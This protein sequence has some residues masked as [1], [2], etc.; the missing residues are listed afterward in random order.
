MRLGHAQRVYA[1]GLAPSEAL[2]VT[3]LKKSWWHIFFLWSM[4]PKSV[5]FVVVW[6]N[7]DRVSKHNVRCGCRYVCDAELCARALQLM[8]ASANAGNILVV[9]VM[10]GEK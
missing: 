10:E 6:H 3:V 5:A 1:P 8:R 2:K 9:T 7:N 4:A